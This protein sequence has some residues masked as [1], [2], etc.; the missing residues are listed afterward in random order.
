METKWNKKV[1]F[2]TNKD[3]EKIYLSAPSWDCDW[4]WGFGYLGNKDCH[5]HLSGYQ[6]KNQERRNKNMYDCLTED[7]ALNEKIKDNLWEFCELVKTA[8]TLKKTAEVLG[9]GGSHYTTNP[10]KD[11]I[12]NK[13]EAK[14][15][16][17]IVLPTIFNAIH[18]LIK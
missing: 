4:Y 17:E 5:Y 9:R 1:F 3:N 10:C 8:Y 12:I 16:N 14:R 18:K 2:G 6:N 13:D 15:I 11:I 7:Y